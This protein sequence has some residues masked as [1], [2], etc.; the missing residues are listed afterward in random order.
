VRTGEVEPDAAAAGAAGGG[1]TRTTAAGRGVV[2]LGWLAG[3]VADEMA[4]S[5]E[6]GTRGVEDAIGAG[7]AAA[8]VDVG[9]ALC[10]EPPTRCV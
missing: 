6:G 7:A 4:A 8:G 10:S 9:A 2:A 3:L 5:L 1:A